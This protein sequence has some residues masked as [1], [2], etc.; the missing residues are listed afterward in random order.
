MT[1]LAYPAAGLFDQGM[2]WLNFNT[3][4]LPQYRSF[5]RSFYGVDG[6]IVPG[7][8]TISGKP[9]GG[10]G[11]YSLS[12]THS[13]WVAQAFYLHW[14]YTRDPK[15]LRE[16]AYP[17]CAAVGTALRGL[18]KP[19]GAGHTRLPLSSSPEIYDNSYKAWLPPNS[20]YDQAL[21]R[22][23]FAANGEMAAELGQDAEQ[24]TDSLKGLEALD[25][26][27]ATGA[28]TFARGFPFNVSHRHF[29]HAMAIH[30]LG[31]LTV[32]GTD[33]DRRTIAATLEQ[34]ERQGTSAWCGYSFS[35]FAAMN[36]RA[37]RADKALDY[38][39]KYER[40]F[41]GPNGFHLN[42]DQSG[43]GLSSFRYRPFTL[44]GNFLAMQAVHEMLLQSW[45]PIGRPGTV[46]V[47]PAV[48]ESWRD[49][50]FRDLRAEGALR[51][52]ARREGGRAVW[53]RI[54]AERPGRVLLRDPFAG[55]NPVWAGIRPTRS[56]QGWTADLPEGGELE[57]RIG[58]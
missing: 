2:S 55:H 27:P 23:I 38:L 52:S 35:W 57:G 17:F 41:I 58:D 37:G 24:W 42:G 28:L 32:D 22:F 40:G 14:R 47:F 36:A 26:D 46:R 33:E 39:K 20:N 25:T 5:A 31:L 53:V 18:L 15:F 12:P 6:A 30:P 10:W 9:M 29:S 16:S 54:V 11:Q 45:G 49:V 50:S 13:A 19:D 43:T 34:I 48:P 3:R 8:M 4:L 56:E 1:Y 51:V 21:L 44:E 7:V